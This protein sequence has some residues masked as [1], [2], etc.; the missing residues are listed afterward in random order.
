MARE[1]RGLDLL[2]DLLDG[3]GRMTLLLRRTVEK[4]MKTP[5]SPLMMMK[6]YCWMVLAGRRLRRKPRPSTEVRMRVFLRAASSLSDR[7][8]FLGRGRSRPCP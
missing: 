6:T 3:R 5:A 7:L 1:K 8:T 2:E 4:R